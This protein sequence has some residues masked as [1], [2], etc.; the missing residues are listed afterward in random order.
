MTVAST[1]TPGIKWVTVSP[2]MKLAAEWRVN[3]SERKKNTVVQLEH[4]TS[5]P[6][7]SRGGGGVGQALRIT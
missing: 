2:A 5:C 6:G 3:F 4:V 7:L 1:G